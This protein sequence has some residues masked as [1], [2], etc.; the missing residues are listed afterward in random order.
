MNKVVMFIWGLVIVGLCTVILM[1]GY[2]EQDR[3]YLKLTKEIKTAAKEYVKDNRAN[4]KTGDSIII[5][6]NDL[7]SGQYV[8]ENDKI[9]KYCIEGVVYSNHIFIDDYEVKINCDNKPVE[10]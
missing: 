5:Y 3:D 8:E 6:I 4:V 1:I 7:I 10:E 9:K 2:K